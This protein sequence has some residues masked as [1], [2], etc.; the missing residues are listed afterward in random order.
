MARKLFNPAASFNVASFATIAAFQ[1][2]ATALLQATE[3]AKTNVSKAVLAAVILQQ[4]REPAATI[5]AAVD[6][7]LHS[8]GRNPATETPSRLSIA[9]GALRFAIKTGIIPVARAGMTEKDALTLVEAFC[10]TYT[11]RGLYKAGRAE[12]D[13]KAAG[14]REERKVETERR[15]ED[16]RANAGVEGPIPTQWS[17]VKL[18]DALKPIL[19]AAATGDDDNALAILETM[20]GLISVAIVSGEEAKAKAKAEAEAEAAKPLLIAA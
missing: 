17:M 11:L 3:D 14:K 20:R 7:A 13:A 8:I 10:S 4:M 18:A 2:S 12:P 9:R 16:M 1:K 6:G 5:N 19:D 15:E